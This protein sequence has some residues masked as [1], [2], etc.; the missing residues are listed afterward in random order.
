VADLRTFLAEMAVDADRFAEFLRAPEDAMRS[1]EL[2]EEDREALL[3]GIPAMIW[4][5]LAAYLAF[6]PPYYSPSLIYVQSVR[7]TYVTIAPLMYENPQP[8]NMPE[9]AI[10]YVTAAPLYVTAPPPLTI[11]ASPHFV[12]SAPRPVMPD[13][14]RE[15]PAPAS[16]KTPPRKRR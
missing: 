2:S 16:P 10:K 13:A 9:T 15:S 14:P 7:P 6:P 5:R 11:P 3:S 8:P 4:A 12:T 1:A